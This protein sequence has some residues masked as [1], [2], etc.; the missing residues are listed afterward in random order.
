MLIC[1]IFRV[2][3]GTAHGFTLFDYT[4][5][6][7]IASKCTLNPQDHTGDPNL[8]RTKKFTQSLRHSIRRLRDRRRIKAEKKDKSPKGSPKKSSKEVSEA[9]AAAEVKPAET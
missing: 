5:K 3:A 4:Q 6:K 8:S 9:S 2:A 7:E 1:D